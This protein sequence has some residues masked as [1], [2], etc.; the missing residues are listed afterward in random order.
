MFAA[1]RSLWQA[2]VAPAE[3]VQYLVEH[4][5]VTG[6][7]EV[8]LRQAE[9]VLADDVEIAALHGEHVEVAAESRAGVQ[10]AAGGS[11]PLQHPRVVERRVVQRARLDPP[12]DQG[13]LFGAVLDHARTDT[14]LG[15]HA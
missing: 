15:G 7:V 13:V 8:V 10:R 3:R 4:P 2:T 14:E 12:D 5:D 9:P 6:V 11:D 1:S